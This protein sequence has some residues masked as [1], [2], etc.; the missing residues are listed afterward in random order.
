[1]TSDELL[2][3]LSIRIYEPPLSDLRS[4]ELLKNASD[5]FATIMLLI[6]FRTELEMN[7]IFNFFGNSTGAYA[8]ET[9]V[10]LRTVGAHKC[11][12]VLEQ[13]IQ[14][15]SAVGMTYEAI[16]EDRARLEEYTVTSW[17]EMHGDKWKETENKINDLDEDLDWDEFDECLNKHVHTHFDL[18]AARLAEAE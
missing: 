9:A 8:P 13:M 4:A 11:A 1:M 18:L 3:E 14:T 2:S 10:A 6:D 15:A 7:G 17:N 12:D 16:Q 5:P